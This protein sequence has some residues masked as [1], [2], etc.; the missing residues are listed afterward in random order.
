QIV[1]AGAF[2][3]PKKHIISTV[4]TALFLIFLVLIFLSLYVALGQHNF[5]ISNFN[6]FDYY[7]NIAFILTS[8]ALYS[9]VQSYLS[10]KQEYFK[11]GVYTFIIYSAPFLLAIIS[12]QLG[13]SATVVIF[14]YS[15]TF[16]LSSLIVYFLVVSDEIKLASI[17]SSLSS[18]KVLKL[19]V[20]NFVRVSLFGFITMLSLYFSV[21]YVNN[22]YN[23]QLAALYSV[24][25]QFFQIGI[26]LPSVLGAVFI[27]KLVEGNSKDLNK[28]MKKSYFLTSIIWVFICSL[29]FY[30]IFKL[31]KFSFEKEIVLTFI[32]MQLGVVFCSVQAFYNQKYVALGRFNFLSSN[33][34]LWGGGLLFCQNYF[35]KILYF[36]SISLV[37][38]YV[39]SLSSFILN[40]RY[41]NE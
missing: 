13:Y 36:S 11:L 23:Q 3:D 28:S 20:I 32:I 31:Y 9:I 12:S 38:A 15:I 16:F 41:F 19:N 2:S 30:P 7:F 27:P 35:P 26:F 29:I 24:S 25:Y 4:S 1:R 17:I 8:L 10:Y 34:L 40:D 6:K 18:F 39:I 5:G 33:A 21:K 22:H 37:V 14:F